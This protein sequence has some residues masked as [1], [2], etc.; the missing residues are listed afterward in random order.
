MAKHTDFGY[1]EA[2]WQW[3]TDEPTGKQLLTHT[4]HPHYWFDPERYK[5]PHQ[6]VDLVAHMSEKTWITKDDLLIIMDRIVT[7][8]YGRTA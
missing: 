1:R 3:K 7:F 8:H 6:L 5:T 2:S 4:C